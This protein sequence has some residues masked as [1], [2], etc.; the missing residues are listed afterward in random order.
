MITVLLFVVCQRAFQKGFGDANSITR[1]DNI[2]IIIL[3]RLS[4]YNE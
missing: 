1:R 3:A 2:F 4:I